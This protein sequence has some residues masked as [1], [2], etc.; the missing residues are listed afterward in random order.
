MIQ[1]SST[2]AKLKIYE[3]DHTAPYSCE[4]SARKDAKWVAF[5]AEHGF[6]VERDLHTKYYALYLELCGHGLV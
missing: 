5:C 1:I 3:R 4:Y 2:Y 6:H